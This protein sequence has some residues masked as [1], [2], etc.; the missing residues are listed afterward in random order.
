MS[1]SGLPIRSAEIRLREQ[2]GSSEREFNEILSALNSFSIVAIT[3][4]RGVI[5][6]VNDRFCEISRYSRDELVGQ[7]H[8][9]INSGRHPKEFFQEMWRVI[10]RGGVWKNEICNRAKD[11]TE[12]WVDTTIIPLLDERGRP[13]R[14][15]AIRTEETQRHLAEE[16]VREL[17]FRDR[18]TGLPNRA[19]MLQAI[20]ADGDRKP[21]GELSGF[22]SVSVDDLSVVNDAFGYQAGDR[23]LVDSARRLRGLDLH[24]SVVS[25]IGANTFGILLPR[26]G[27][28]LEAS[29]RRA[30][31]CVD[32]VLDTLTGTVDLES[33]VVIDATASAGYV[34]WT[35]PE[36]RGDD[37]GPG[38]CDSHIKTTDAHEIIK[39]ADIARKHARRA[40]G[41]RR[42]R[43][44][45][46]SMLDDAQ[47]R[48][49]LISELRRGIENGELRLFSQPIVDREQRVIGEEG[50]IRWVSPERGLVEPGAFIPLAEQTGLIV[51]I[52]EWVLEEA[53]GVLAAW[54]RD[55]ER[56]HRTFS[57]NLSERQLRVDDFAERVR[58]IIAK[59]GVSPGR[60][61]LELTESVLHT[62]LDRTV[63]LLSLLRADGVLASLDDF[64][65]GYSS[66]S[67]L[68]Q[69]PVQ[70]LKIDR[71]F[72]FSVV[73]DEASASIVRTIVQLGRTF[74]LQVVAEGVETRQQFEKLLELGVDA[75]QGYLF[76]RPRPVDE[77][78]DA[79]G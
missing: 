43:H 55:P 77:S 64:G 42:I 58:A 78:I 17:A 35:A 14:Y 19:S 5:L 24:D 41:P 23:L 16:R 79:I 62:D 29:D 7:T 46:Q 10:G 25:R 18:V 56:E 6:H 65:T 48:V 9:I 53:C 30:A 69:L 51:E 1:E 49:R 13:E 34:L 76:A 22:I 2:F 33:G 21:E 72:T 63:K 50:L 15:V 11:G 20:E 8:R 27:R 44:F 3:D 61:K 52:G 12:Y 74:A 32:Q 26:L 68:R 59:H 60:L 54:E 67:Y 70:Q 28:D 36:S 71:S 37:C 40:G 73:E 45:R 47:R 38:A 4:R 66:L 31:E 75:F 39:C 57:V